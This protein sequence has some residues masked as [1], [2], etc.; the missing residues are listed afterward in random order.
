M[1]LGGGYIEEVK[2]TKKLNCR[3]CKFSAFCFGDEYLQTEGVVSF[4]TGFDDYPSHFEKEKKLIRE[5]GERLKQLQ[6]VLQ[7]NPNSDTAAFL[8]ASPSL[9]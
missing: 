9:G 5:K 6:K 1:S 4:E 2:M 7:G 8:L 3:L